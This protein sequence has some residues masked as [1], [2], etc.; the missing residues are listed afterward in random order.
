MRLF[1]VRDAD[2]LGMLV[3]MLKSNDDQWVARGAR[4]VGAWVAGNHN[5]QSLVL[6][7][8]VISLLVDCLRC[9]SSIQKLHAGMALMHVS[10]Q[11]RVTS[12]QV[13][14][15]GALLAVPS[16]LNARALVVRV[17]GAGIIT[18]LLGLFDYSWGTN[19]GIFKALVD[20]MNQCED[21][22]GIVAA[23]AIFELVHRGKVE[24]HRL[25]ELPVIPRVLELILLCPYPGFRRGAHRFL[26]Q[27]AKHIAATQAMRH[28]AG[29]VCQE[30]IKRLLHAMTLHVTSI[31]E[32][33]IHVI[34]ILLPMNQHYK[35][36]VPSLEK[37]ERLSMDATVGDSGRSMCREVVSYARKID[38]EHRTRLQVFL[39]TLGVCAVLKIIKIF[40]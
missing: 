3:C 39:T 5:I 14:K 23:A 28:G 21:Y 8:G 4:I 12:M 25:T 31:N 29:K 20:L 17:V 9:G 30:A 1:R 26:V 11:N 24:L 40:K 37:F 10:F 27:W 35:W 6:E 7:S 33:A 32:I 15:D 18:H 2:L 36:V 22:A 38:M 34:W 16:L 19:V 13:L